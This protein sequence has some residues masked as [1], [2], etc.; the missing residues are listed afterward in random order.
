MA[1]PINL[2]QKAA[3][4]YRASSTGAAAVLAFTL[5]TQSVWAQSPSPSAANRTVNVNYVYAA[6]LG[7]G[8]YSLAGLT[9]DVFA[10]PLGYTFPLGTGTGWS[11]R[12][13]LPVQLGLYSFRATDTDGTPI[14]I[15][16]QSLAAVPGA[17]LR[18]PIARNVVL[19]PFAQVGFGHA[20]GTTTGANFVTYT[21][22]ARSVVQWQAGAYTLS[23]GNAALYAGDQASNFR[24][25][26]VSLQAGFEVRRPLGF[27]VRGIEPDLGVF[28]SEYYYPKPLRFSRFLRDPLE[29]SE[30]TEIGVTIG[31]TK[32]FDTVLLGN[33]RIG[34]GYV[35][36]DGLQVWHVAFGFPF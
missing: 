32:P 5:A 14:K 4:G 19:K 23:L 12:L 36:G 10:L 34:A 33:A 15:D 13:T 24:E 22:G 16:Q 7:F 31:S 29:V 2:S 30:Q 18:V 11:L 28:V 9:A 6:E 25:S 8:G 3:P 26:Y 17:E 1:T 35:F 20:F 27:T 21:A